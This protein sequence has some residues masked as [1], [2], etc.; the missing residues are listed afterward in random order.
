MSH[1]GSRLVC[2]MQKR[3]AGAGADAAHG[4][5]VRIE[6]ADVAELERRLVRLSAAGGETSS[7]PNI[8]VSSYVVAACGTD[9]MRGRTGG[10]L[11]AKDR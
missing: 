3:L 10:E 8:R 4:W 11:V 9:G 6:P 7:F 1:C 5:A 2:R